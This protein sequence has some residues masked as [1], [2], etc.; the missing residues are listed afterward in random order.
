VP[1]NLSGDGWS[2]DSATGTL[3]VTT[4]AATVL[5]RGFVQARPGLAVVMNL[6]AAMAFNPIGF[7]LSRLK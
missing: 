7:L 1:A 5:W 3:T 2:F 4:S 6:A